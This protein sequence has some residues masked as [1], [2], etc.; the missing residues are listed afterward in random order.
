MVQE[1][2]YLCRA[3]QCR[4]GGNKLCVKIVHALIAQQQRILVVVVRNVKSAFEERSIDLNV[5]SILLSSKSPISCIL[6]M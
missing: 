4:K 6:Y 3:E 5:K 2:L 1:T